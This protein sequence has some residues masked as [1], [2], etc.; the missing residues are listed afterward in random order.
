MDCHAVFMIGDVKAQLMIILMLMRSTQVL[1]VCRYL[2]LLVITSCH[3]ARSY[4]MLPEEFYHPVYSSMISPT[5][6]CIK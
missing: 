1:Y 6:A 5:N 3:E 4:R 2:L